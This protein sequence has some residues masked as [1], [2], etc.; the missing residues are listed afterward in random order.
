MAEQ[1]RG[2]SMFTTGTGSK[3]HHPLVLLQHERIASGS[4]VFSEVKTLRRLQKSGPLP[5]GTVVL[6]TD[7]RSTRGIWR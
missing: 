5:L 4:F 3:L 7:M 1:L 2:L 6:S